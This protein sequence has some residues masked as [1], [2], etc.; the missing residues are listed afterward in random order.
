TCRADLEA[1]HFPEAGHADRILAAGRVAVDVQNLDGIDALA[2]AGAGVE[3]VRGLQPPDGDRLF[4]V[5]HAGFAGAGHAFLETAEIVAAV[6]QPGVDHVGLTDILHAD[7]AIGLPALVPDAEAAAD[8]RTAADAVHRAALLHGV[9]LL[10]GV[11]FL[12][13]T[14]GHILRMALGGP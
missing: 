1:R 11:D 2:V 4:P 6:R 13:M 8:G 14:L 3:A 5:G 7:G 12:D 9:L 10:R